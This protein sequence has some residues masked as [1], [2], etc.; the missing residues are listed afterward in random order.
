VNLGYDNLDELISAFMAADKVASTQL[1]WRSK[2]HPDYSECTIPVFCPAMPEINSRLIL[3]AHRSRRP[4]KYGFSLLAADYRVLGLDV[5][6]GASH[7]NVQTLTSIS[8]TH[9]QAWPTMEAV[10][11]D[12]DLPH[13]QWLL[14]FLSRAKIAY[15]GGYEP[16]PFVEPQLKLV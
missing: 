5:N 4:C 7:F 3:V 8:G 12:R 16:P 2:G 11:D 13:R 9:W 1:K 15:G 6:P 14:D 10:A